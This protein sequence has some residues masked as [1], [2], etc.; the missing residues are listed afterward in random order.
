M[1][2]VVLPYLSCLRTC[3]ATSFNKV[4]VSTTTQ[5][6]RGSSLVMR[7]NSVAVGDQELSEDR[8]VTRKGGI[9]LSCVGRDQL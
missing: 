3:I 4:S 2:S 9:A 8:R 7:P 6:D 5:L 1:C